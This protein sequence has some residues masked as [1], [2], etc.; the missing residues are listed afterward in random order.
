MVNHEFWLRYVQVMLF[1]KSGWECSGCFISPQVKCWRK[2][3]SITPQQSHSFSIGEA[4]LTSS[5]LD[6]WLFCCSA[7]KPKTFTLKW[8]RALRH[9]S[10]HVH[11]QQD[12]YCKAVSR[13]QW[14]LCKWGWWDSSGNKNVHICQWQ[15]PI[16]AIM[17]QFS[18]KAIL[19]H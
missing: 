17:H 5:D 12:F 13:A 8:C 10:D 18:F 19:A 4:L 1:L 16:Q 15:I 9:Q 3:S 6:I 11:M 7:Q 2:V 14:H